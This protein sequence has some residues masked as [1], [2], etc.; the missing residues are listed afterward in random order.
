M[1]ET[2]QRASKFM[3]IKRAGPGGTNE[4]GARS[5]RR[6]A[7][8]RLPSSQL[9]KGPPPNTQLKVQVTLL[10]PHACV[11]EVASRTPGG[12][13]CLGSGAKAPEGTIPA[14]SH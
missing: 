14:P 9:L 7:Q 2:A 13:V 4:T 10:C 11:W 12:G 3:V 6:T 5:H 1:Q 8:A